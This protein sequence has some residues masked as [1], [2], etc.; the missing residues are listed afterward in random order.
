[1]AAN[2][3]NRVTIPVGLLPSV[4]D[5]NNPS[6]LSADARAMAEDWTVI[7]DIRAGIVKIKEKAQ[8]YLPKF[9]MED[10]GAY[11]V[12]LAQAPWRPE[13]TDALRNLCSKPFTK[14]VVV[15]EDAPDDV[16]GKVVNDET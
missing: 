1:M 16:I 12:R 10:F 4:N 8:K 11:K 9:Q 2:D 7:A 13:F 14:K 6:T 15:N 3:P 5:Q